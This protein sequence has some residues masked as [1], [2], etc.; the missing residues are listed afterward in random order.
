MVDLVALYEYIC[1]CFS[2]KLSECCQRMSN[3][4]SP[5]FTD[6]EVLTIFIYGIMH[7]QFTIAN[8]YRFTKKFLSSW[9]PRLPS[10]Q[11]FNYRLNRIGHVFPALIKDLQTYA[12]QHDISFDISLLDSYP[13]MMANAKRSEQAKVA[14]LLADKGYCGSKN[15]YYYGTKLH[16]VATKRH[17]RIP[18]PEWMGITPASVHDLVAVREVLVQLEGRKIFADKIYMDQS[19][20][21][22]LAQNHNIELLTPVKKK[23]KQERLAFEDGLFSTLVSK[24]RQPIESLFNWLDQNTNLQKAHTVRA[25]AGLIV[26]V[27]GRIAAAMLLMLHPDFNS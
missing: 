19:F 5:A 2:H 6:Q 18:I 12:T 13:I 26:H 15:T 24:V 14:P 9:F 3:N 10:Y 11:Q 23:P 4:H 16:V 8:I 1:E 7:N 25:E 22:E 21:D 17:G 20:K 27:F